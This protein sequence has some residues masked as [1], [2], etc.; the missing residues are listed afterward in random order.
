M[1][2][3]NIDTDIFNILFS[4]AFSNEWECA[5]PIKDLTNLEGLIIK[6]IPEDAKTIEEVESFEVK[7]DVIGSIFWSAKRTK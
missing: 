1:S 4:D 3:N 6:I 2:N 5:E 7:E